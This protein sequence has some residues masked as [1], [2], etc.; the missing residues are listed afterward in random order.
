MRNY[1]HPMESC[2]T[3]TAIFDDVSNF[4]Q[5]NQLSWDSL[6]G[7]CTDEAP[8]MLGLQ[9]GFTTRVKEKNPSVVGTHCILHRE[10]LASRTLPAEMRD[11]LNVAI[12][13]VNFIKAGALNSRLFKLL[14]KDMESE[15]EALLFHTNVRWLSKGN[16]L[17]RLYE[18][19]EEVAMFLD[20]QQKAALHDKFQSESFRLSLAYL[21][22]IFEA[23]N[24]LNLKLQGKN[25][26]IL[27][28]HDTIRTF[29]AK[30]DL[31]KCRIQQGNTASF[32]CLD[33]ALI[34]GNLDSVLKKQIITH[35][36]DLKTEFIRYFPYID[37]K[38][39][40]WKFIRNPFQCEVADVSDEVQEEFLELQF[41]STAKEDFKELDLETFW[42]KYL[43][44]YPL[45]SHQA[46]R[47][48]TMFGS[49]YLCEAAF[50][51]LVAVKTKYRNRLNVEGD[52]RC[53]LS[54]I[55]PRIQDLVAKKQCQV[56]H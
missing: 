5:E 16:M 46:L 26:N 15:H 10:A 34:H 3:A 31:W 43:P 20:L 29:M 19:R 17:G 25:I 23:L 30:L 50:S 12:K 21:V 14:C 44:V 54:G 7:V 55:Q 47:I 9:S 13:V 22:D 27:M 32:S 33:F 40:A 24:A 42:V 56:S 48:L 1:Y 36:N 18:L 6:T 41:N 38:R 4:F 28:H 39:E 35:L 51:T 49:T 37:E 45:I 8:A 53:A 2:T 11:V 52:L